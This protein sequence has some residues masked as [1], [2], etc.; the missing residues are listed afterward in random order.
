MRTLRLTRPTIGQRLKEP[1]TILPFLAR[2]TRWVRSPPFEGFSDPFNAQK[3]RLELIRSVQTAFAPDACIETGTFLGHTT[4]Y[5]AGWGVP[6]FTVE[7][8]PAWY[9]LAAPS[10]RRYSNVTLI[11]G[12]SQEAIPL[13]ADRES[14]ARPFVY[15]DAHLPQRNPSDHLEDHPLSKE[16]A[17]IVSAWDEAIIVID[18]F[19]VPGEPG[20]GYDI[21]EGVPLSSELLEPSP[22]TVLAY[23]VISPR[24]ET[25]AR[26]GSAFIGH[27]PS[28]R[29]VLERLIDDGMLT[30]SET[31][32]GGPHPTPGAGG[33]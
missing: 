13:L 10:L 32:Q 3:G 14:F 25:G 17:M 19:L 5:L 27:G 1:L 16:F 12:D 21:V 24:E 7:R 2:R 20:Y 9:R 15:L 26:R 22:G 18:D 4:R 6:V 33:P 30:P 11:C 23:P 29:T 8:N 28:G 31:L